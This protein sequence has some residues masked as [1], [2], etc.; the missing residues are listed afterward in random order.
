MYIFTPNWWKNGLLTCSVNPIENEV[1]VD[2]V[3]YLESSIPI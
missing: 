1:V 2:E 3:I